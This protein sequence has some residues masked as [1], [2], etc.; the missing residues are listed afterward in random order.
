MD[1]IYIAL[2]FII[3]NYVS[4]PDLVR[5]FLGMPLLVLI[6]KQLGRT[7]VYIFNKEWHFN[8][9]S[10]FIIDCCIGILMQFLLA[11]TL[12]ILNIFNIYL[13]TAMILTI[14]LY[15]KIKID[16]NRPQSIQNHFMERLEQVYTRVGGFKA[17]LVSLAL[18]FVPA[19]LLVSQSPFPLKHASD[20]FQYSMLVMEI[21]ENNY[22]NLFLI[23]HIPFLPTLLS[24]PS[25]L[26]NI[27]PF[28]FFWGLPLLL[29]P[30][31]S[32]GLYLFSYEISHN[33]LL[34]LFASLFGVWA[35]GGWLEVHLFLVSPR[36]LI[37][38]LF[39]FFLLNIFND[40]VDFQKVDYKDILFTMSYAAFCYFTINL[41][42]AQ[43]SHHLPHVA[44]VLLPIIIFGYSGIKLT[45]PKLKVRLDTRY[46]FF[47]AFL[48]LFPYLVYSLF[49]TIPF[50][51]SVGAIISF[52]FLTLILFTNL[53]PH[54]TR[55]KSIIFIFLLIF[56]FIHQFLGLVIAFIVC[57]IIF[58]SKLVQ[59]G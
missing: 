24:L 53:R 32:F 13:Y 17:A 29:Y 46:L 25:M 19:L 56:F 40:Y 7:F 33:E 39:P 22:V 47:I 4:V 28:H 16:T 15:K 51:T 21:I 5:V 45:P 20:A 9:V 6:P 49:S 38:F 37:M 10:S 30:L 48:P 36:D 31:F 41:A 42:L 23:N 50:I 27:H 35:F 44:I 3:C 2:F 11:L 43:S 8:L 58:L 55:S 52:L 18:G 34:S 57:F 26:F 54:I 1:L 59:R 14:L 12:Q